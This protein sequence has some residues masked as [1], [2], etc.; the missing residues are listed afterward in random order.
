MIEAQ[1][2]FSA[3][4]AAAVN[5]TVSAVSAQSAALAPGT[6]VFCCDQDCNILFG[7]NPTATATCFFVPAKQM[8]RITGVLANDICAVIA[9]GAGTA[10]LSLGI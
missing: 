4:R 2:S 5:I 7:A 9:A 8:F 6:Y 10:R 1:I 3:P